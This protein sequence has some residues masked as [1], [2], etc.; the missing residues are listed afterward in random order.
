MIEII[1]AAALLLVKVGQ[2]IA[3]A[4]AGKYKTA[5]E[6]KAD[7]SAAVDEFST[8]L[9]GLEAAEAKNDADADGEAA[10]P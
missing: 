1:T 8:K 9:D 7:F 4:V 10:K 5:E 2:I 6:A 3:D